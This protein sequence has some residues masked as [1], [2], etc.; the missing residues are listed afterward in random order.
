MNGR[1]GRIARW[2]LIAALRL[3]APVAELGRG[4][5]RR[6]R[7]AATRRRW[8]RRHRCVAERTGRRRQRHRRHR[9]LR[10][11]RTGIIGTITG[12]ASIC[13]GGVEVHYD[14]S[15]QVEIDGE[16]APVAR[17]AVGQSSRSSPRV[18]GEEVTAKQIAVRHVVAGPITSIDAEQR[19]VAGHGSACRAS[20][21]EH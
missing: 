1:R 7:P 11:R 9:H 17:L 19:I 16:P 3:C 4:A 13:V 20:G 15:S 12:F 2:L 21:R 5:L 18:R 8:Y 10:Q 14:A 6:R